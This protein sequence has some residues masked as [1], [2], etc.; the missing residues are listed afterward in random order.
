MCRATLLLHPR[1]CLHLHP[2]VMLLRLRPPKTELSHRNHRQMVPRAPRKMLYQAK[3]QIQM[4]IHNTGINI[5]SSC[6]KPGEKCTP[7][8]DLLFAFLRCAALLGNTP[9]GSVLSHA[10]PMLYRAAYGYDVNSE[11]FKQWQATQQQQYASYYAG[12]GYD[13]TGVAS[14]AAAGNSGAQPPPP[15]P[16]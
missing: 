7:S 10:M 5:F 3:H 14:G 6:L 11:Q 16:S 1:T 8:H 12:Q 4:H 13:S 15:P 9:S 2:R